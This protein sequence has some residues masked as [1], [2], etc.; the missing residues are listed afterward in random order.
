[1]YEEF[2]DLQGRP[3]LPT[4]RAD[5]YVRAEVIERARETL[6]RGIQ[7]G[8]GP[9]LLIGPE[10][11]GKT[12]LCQLLAREFADTFAVVQLASGR[13]G[14]RTALLQSILYDLGQPYRAMDEG[15]LRLALVDFLE[16]SP[17]GTAG[18]LLLVDEAHSLPLRLLEEMRLLTNL[19]TAKHKL[20][21]VVLVGQ[22][23]LRALLGRNDLRQL[24]QRI[25]ARYHLM[26]LNRAETAARSEEH[27]SELQSH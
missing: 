27:T 10:G 21:Q 25:T 16:P 8:E 12:L 18:M 7:R 26:P 5:R 9:G 13:L 3:F 1:M 19:E 14:T 24:A 17:E 6:S 20:L 23:E 22:P 11:T 15:E 2:F 4:P